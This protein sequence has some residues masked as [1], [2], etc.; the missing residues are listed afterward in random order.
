M[1]SPVRRGFTLIELLVVIAII[2]ILI[3]LLLPAVQKVREAAAR[4]QC[5]NNLKQWALALHGYHDALGYFPAWGFTFPNT[6]PPG[7]GNDRTGHSEMVM[8]LEYI[9]Q[10]NLANLADRTLPSTHPVN[11]PPPL[12]M[13]IAGQQVVKVWICPSVPNGTELIDY[14]PLGYTGLRLGRTDYFAFR[15]V[16]NDFR[17][18]CATTTP[19]DSDD[20]GALSPKGGKPRLVDIRDGTSNTML[21]C[22]IGGRSN[23]YVQG[24]IVTPQQ[25]PQPN[26]SQGMVIRG[27]WGD[28]NG[29]SR[30]YAYTVSGTTVSVGGCNGA[31]VVN[32]EQPYSLHP[33]GVN[34]A[35]ADGSVT[36][37][38]Y[39]VAAPALAAYIT[40]SGGEVLSI[41][42]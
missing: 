11:L 4:A 3:G 42:N 14:S 40:R 16:S 24:K 21:L 15:G 2:A 31:G 34:T 39:G 32:L 37:M 26:S 33:G 30:L 27:A 36:F 25:N 28:Q 10:G 5:E 9:E 6:T 12:G 20:G 29:A 19:I 35:R 17:N 18:A 41:D 1:R 8:A 13:S 22:E 7:L 23:M 38:R